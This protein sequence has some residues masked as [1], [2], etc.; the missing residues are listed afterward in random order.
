MCGIP[1]VDNWTCSIN[2][3]VTDRCI[4]WAWQ[5]WNFMGALQQSLPQTSSA[6]V[7]GDHRDPY[8]QLIMANMLKSVYSTSP[9]TCSVRKKKTPPCLPTYPPPPLFI[10]AHTLR[11]YEASLIACVYRAAVWVASTSWQH[12]YDFWVGKVCNALTHNKA[13]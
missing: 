5:T 3:L 12:M 8:F 1:W 13:E 2:V 7:F 9:L 11:S 10:N 4:Y 6:P